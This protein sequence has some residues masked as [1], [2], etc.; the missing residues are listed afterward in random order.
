MLIDCTLAINSVPGTQ[1]SEYSQS[2]SLP[3][4]KTD[5]IIAGSGITPWAASTTYRPAERILSAFGHSSCCIICRH[6][7]HHTPLPPTDCPM[8][9]RAPN[10]GLYL[11]PSRSV[12]ARGTS[13]HRSNESRI[14]NALTGSNMHRRRDTPYHNRAVWRRYQ[15]ALTINYCYY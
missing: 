14:H 10:I 7:Y 4:R 9:Q 5:V 6:V 3:V 2:P 8:L 12:R 1:C 13:S 11:V 15:G